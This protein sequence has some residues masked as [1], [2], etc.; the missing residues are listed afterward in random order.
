MLQI[1]GFGLNKELGSRLETEVEV[2]LC[3]ISSV[4]ALGNLEATPF[5][6]L[7]I[8]ADYCDYNDFITIRQFKVKHAKI[9]IIFVG[10]ELV[11]ISVL[12]AIRSRAW[13]YILLPQ[14]TSR[15]I[16]VVKQAN[17]LSN[18]EQSA[19]RCVV[20]P[21][22]GRQQD[23]STVIKDASTLRTAVALDY[24]LKNYGK[25]IRVDFLAS[26]SNMTTDT[27]SRI[28]KNE[29][30]ETISAFI[31]RVRITNAKKK[32]RSTNLPISTIS[33]EC[34]FEDQTYFCR[35]FRH[36]EGVSS[37]EYRK[38]YYDKIK[39]LKKQS[40]GEKIFQ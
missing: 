27:F 14:E 37:T 36:L 30:H 19:R 15:L 26:L 24:V 29:N 25:T 23:I 13:D 8:N 33:Y 22:K 32:L 17:E 40:I 39:K 12:A 38:A 4:T 3:N 35:V 6:T 20:F 31:K 34:G 16:D 10:E 5:K 2:S 18:I 7:I 28:F 1:M 9:P 11:E 21:G